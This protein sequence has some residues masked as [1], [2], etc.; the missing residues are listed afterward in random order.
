MAG[1]DE[2]KHVSV[3][4]ASVEHADDIARCHAGLFE[5]PWDMASVQGLLSHPGS[6]ALVA[7]VGYPPEVAGFILGQLAADEAEIL[8]F[9][10]AKDFQRHGIGKKLLDG[11]ARAAKRA[12]AKRLFLEVADDNIPALVLYSRSGFKEVGRR[13]GYYERANGVKADA[14][15][16]ALTL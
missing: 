3:L 8:S 16:L 11:L 6:T 13:K 10:V 14:L 1:Q 12:E 4:W 5:T 2:L 15:V 9:G 7:R